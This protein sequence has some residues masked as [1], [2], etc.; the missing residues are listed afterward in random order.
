MR[1]ITIEK[2]TL[3]IGTGEPGPKLDKAMKLLNMITGAKPVQ[4]TTQKRIPG[5]KIRPGL[6]IGC[7]V[8]LRKNK[9]IQALK[10][11]LSGI[12]YKIGERQFDDYGNFAFGIKEY[13]DIPSIKYNPDIGVIGLEVAVTLQRKGFRLKHRAIKRR[14][15]SHL[16]NITKVE[17]IQFIK[18]EF[19]VNVVN[20]E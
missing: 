5:W 2:I 7:K 3:N 8:T 10:Q 15:I 1:S 6:V 14:K 20:E 17:A 9:A 4:T 16:H 18:D 12:D 11:L 13:I 19:K